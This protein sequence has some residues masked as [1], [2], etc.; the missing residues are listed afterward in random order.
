MYTEIKTPFHRIVRK[1]SNIECNP[2]TDVKPYT[3]FCIR[4]RLIREIEKSTGQ[5]IDVSFITKY[6]DG[7]GEI[8]ARIHHQRPINQTDLQGILNSLL[9]FPETCL[10][11]HPDVDIYVDGYHVPHSW[12]QEVI[13][14]LLK[15]M[16]FSLKHP[17]VQFREVLEDIEDPSEN[18]PIVNDIGEVYM[19]LPE[20]GD[21]TDLYER[22]QYDI[23]LKLED[24]FRRGT[25]VDAPPDII[26][27]WKLTKYGPFYCADWEDLRI[28]PQKT[29]FLLEKRRGVR[30]VL[31]PGKFKLT[32]W[33][34]IHK[35]EENKDYTLVLVDNLEDAWIVAGILR[36]YS[37]MRL[38]Q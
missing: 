38:K 10:L 9:K 16:R 30:G 37:F 27:N 14:P 25:L 24:L 2:E 21:Y 31:F 13:K 19:N 6:T 36:Y 34:V 18:R 26:E 20:D 22:Y 3:L 7:H 28:A 5:N 8:Y 32:S 23:L 35:R 11:F 29:L 4:T 33:E 17:Y 15:H 1:P 12:I